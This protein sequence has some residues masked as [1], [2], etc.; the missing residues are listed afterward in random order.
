NIFMVW[1]Y[2]KNLWWAKWESGIWT[3]ADILADAGGS[4]TTLSWD[5]DLFGG[6]EGLLAAW[7]STQGTEEVG[8]A[9]VQW[10]YA[11]PDGGSFAWTTPAALTG[12]TYFDYAPAVLVGADGTPMLVWVTFEPADG[13]DD[14][15]LYYTELTDTKAGAL[16]IPAPG[17]NLAE[18]EH[19][20][21]SGKGGYKCLEHTFKK[22][23]ELPNWIPVVGGKY[24]WEIGGSLC[25]ED[26][27][28]YAH[29]SGSIS[30]GLDLSKN[31]KGTGT[32]TVGAYWQPHPNVPEPCEYLFSY[33]YARFGVEARYTFS[34]P[35]I[36]ILI[37]GIPIG[38]VKIEPF[39][40]GDL[41]GRVR[42]RRLSV[43]PQE[44]DV[45]FNVLAGAKGTLTLLAGA[46]VGEAE[47][48]GTIGLKYDIGPGTLGFA[49][50]CITLKGEARALGIFRKSFIKT[51]GDNCQEKAMLIPYIYGEPIE[52]ITKD[53]VKT[54]HMV[55]KA[56]FDISE[57]VNTV[58]GR[59]A[60]NPQLHYG[61]AIGNTVF[62]EGAQ[63]NLLNEDAPVML[64]VGG[65]PYM[66]WCREAR[67]PG[68]LGSRL[69]ESTYD[70]SNWAAPV[71]VTDDDFNFDV[72]A[73]A[74]SN[75]A[76]VAAWSSSSS[77]GLDY[78]TSSISELEDAVNQ[79]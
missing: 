45:Q 14:A 7:S 4:H 69:Y 8:S 44:G 31:V 58:K 48:S 62:P 50:W 5:D 47:A 55:S 11:R 76:I 42:W 73:V 25:G 29:R 2:D 78:D 13:D 66:L 79:A 34:V 22:G 77:A 35:P 75:G 27:C 70:G 63:T 1:H 54:I 15:D 28:S 17:E 72:T 49:G 20:F 18:S 56:D 32:A 30:L 43:L 53:A 12:N 65:Q 39:I 10:S 61:S 40:G 41:S 51:W 59:T 68:E 33:A 24:G 64:D 60:G 6:G 23:A 71:A 67:E 37:A 21:G 38:D 9:G 52:T 16:W 19:V 3:Q 46:G 36:P 57:E 74:D 26:L